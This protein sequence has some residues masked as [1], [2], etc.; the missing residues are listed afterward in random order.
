MLSLNPR[1]RNLSL[2]IK[3]GFI[4]VVGMKQN[5]RD[6][7]LMDGMIRNITGEYADI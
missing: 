2:G 6:F 5:M 3:R 4:F 1:G 7:A